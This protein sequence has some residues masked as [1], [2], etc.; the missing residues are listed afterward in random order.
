MLHRKMLAPIKT[1]KHYVHLSNVSV[2][3]GS[4][5]ANTLV[6]AVAGEA[7]A[8]ANEVK[9]GSLVKNIFIELWLLGRGASDADTQFNVSLEKIPGQAVNGMTYAQMLNLGAYPNKKN[10][11][12]TSSG[13]IG[14]VGGGQAV[15]VMRGWFKIPKGKQRMGLDDFLT[16]SIAATGE[17]L[18]RCGFST[19]K[20]YL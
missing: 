17:A 11:F 2:A 10:I 18:Q 16:L 12:F 8:N 20:E 19:Y 13:V 9:E 15:P 5:S 14:G 7:T 6:H 4:R 1:I 3:S